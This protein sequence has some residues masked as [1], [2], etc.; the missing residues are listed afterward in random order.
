[1]GKFIKQEIQRK[2]YVEKAR[3]NAIDNLAQLFHA[4]KGD[5]RII[6]SQPEKTDIEWGKMDFRQ[7]QSKLPE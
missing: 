1:M 7:V 4:L 3:K 6:D 2:G 5:V